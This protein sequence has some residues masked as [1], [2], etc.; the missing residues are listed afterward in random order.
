MPF[1]KAI[2][3]THEE[4]SYRAEYDR[5]F[6][7]P[8]FFGSNMNALLLDEGFMKMSLP[9]ANPHLSKVLTARA[10]ELLKSLE[11]SKTTRG[12]VEKL[13]TAKLQ[14]GAASVDDNRAST[15]SEPANTFSQ[16]KGG[17]RYF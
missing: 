7:V 11:S 16:V 15:G 17:G 1:P 10:E 6:G 4:P 8:L 5:I 9:R 2:R 12:E 3:F 13:L 14:S